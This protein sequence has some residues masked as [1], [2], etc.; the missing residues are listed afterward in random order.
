MRLKKIL[1]FI[2]IFFL[3]V[4]FIKKVVIYRINAQEE[5]VAEQGYGNLCLNP[6]FYEKGELTAFPA[7][8]SVF[9]LQGTGFPAN[10]TVY[11]YY[12]IENGSNEPFCDTGVDATNILLFGKVPTGGMSLSYDHPDGVYTSNS[13]GEV[14]IKGKINSASPSSHYFFYGYYFIPPTGTGGEAVE[15]EDKTQQQGILT[16]PSFSSS[17]LEKKCQDIF[18]DPFGRVFDS[19]SL[20]PI[21]GVDVKLLSSINPDI[22]VTMTG[23]QLNPDKT[24]INGVFNFVVPEGI[25]YLRLSNL[26]QT[27]QFISNPNLNSKYKDIYYQAKDGSTSIYQPDQEIKELIDTPKEEKIGRPDLEERDIPLDPG[28]NSPYISQI[29]LMPNSAFQ[30]ANIDAT[31]YRGQSSHPYPIVSLVRVD[32]NQTIYE[33]EITD[34]S[35]RYGYWKIVVPNNQIPADTSLKVVLKKNLK[36]FSVANDLATSKDSFVFEPILRYVKGYVYDSYGK[37]ILDTIVKIKLAMN[38]STF[39]EVKTNDKGLFEIIS[40]KLPLFSYYLSY[41]TD[42]ASTISLLKT[43]SIF[44]QDNKDY[45]SSEKIN[46]M[47]DQNLDKFLQATNSPGQQEN[48]PLS[49]RKV[50]LINK[51]IIIFIIIILLLVISAVAILLYIKRQR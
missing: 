48:T 10:A 27:H 23:G 5:T 41:K 12:C 4:F 6:V 31:I 2:F 37:P 14:D 36:Y 3:I 17:E 33:K 22:K 49:P 46:L 39:S 29:A 43:T 38:N 8:G 1:F 9:E 28:T 18:W 26:P 25:Y 21:S 16:F 51:I 19:V 45:L 47:K 42:P 34:T 11:P 35:G 32:N 30:L 13:Q 7:G 15:G 50:N 20:E 24:G 44:A 40:S